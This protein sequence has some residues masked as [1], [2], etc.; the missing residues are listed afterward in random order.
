M[1]NL[2]FEDE[3]ILIT[4]MLLYMDYVNL[5]FNK[6]L[7]ESYPD[8]TP[9]DFTYLV[10]IMYH[11]DISQKE[12]SEMLFVSESNVTQIIKRLEKNG[13]V[14]R[15]VSKENKSKKILKLTD[16]GKVTLFSILKDIFEWEGKFEENYSGEEIEL[17]KRVL[18][19][20]ADKSIYDA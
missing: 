7:K 6:Y 2:N 17:V 19:D 11:Q 16:K 15:E 9:R 12:L 5:Q 8:I 20:Y 3:R 1:S 18:Y 4:P 13:F 10:N 14:S